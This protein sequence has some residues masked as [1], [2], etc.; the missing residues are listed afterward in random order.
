MLPSTGSDQISAVIEN[1]ISGSVIKPASSAVSRA[2]LGFLGANAGSAAPE[3]RIASAAAAV[4]AAAALSRGLPTEND[5]ES[6]TPTL[7]HAQAIS[8]KASDMGLGGRLPS[9][10]RARA[11]GVATVIRSSF[12]ESQIWASIAANAEE[13][14]G[15][16]KAN[17]KLV[18]EVDAADRLIGTKAGEPWRP[19]RL[20]ILQPTP[21]ETALQ[22]LLRFD[23]NHDDVTRG[24][25]IEENFFLSSF[26]EE[27]E[28]SASLSAQM[29]F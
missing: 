27:D 29:L 24:A 10:R 21:A 5:I 16:T 25:N 19:S 18:M 6:F 17:G 23:N 14:V 4:V 3:A 13:A 12:P 1:G 9:R 8:I 15:I 11:Q 26:F 28:S 7:T 22:E 20:E 2:P